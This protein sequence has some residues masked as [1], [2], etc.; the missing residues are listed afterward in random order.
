MFLSPVAATTLWAE[1][2]TQKRRRK[3]LA[4]QVNYGVERP[5]VVNEMLEILTVRFVSA[6]LLFVLSLA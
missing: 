4:K 6:A 1:N 2:C 5:V 3:I